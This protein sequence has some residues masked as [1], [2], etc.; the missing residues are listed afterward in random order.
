MIGS[1][2]AGKSI[3]NA[4]SGDLLVDSGS[5]N[6]GRSGCH[7][8]KRLAAP[9]LVA[10]VV[11]DPMAGTT[12]A[13]HRRKPGAGLA[14]R[15]ER[16]SLGRAVGRAARLFPWRK[17]SILKLGLE[18]PP[19]RPHWPAVG[20][21]APGGQPADGL[22]PSRMLLLTNTPPRST[23]KTAAFECWNR[24]TKWWRKAN[25]HA[26]G[27]PLMRQGAGPRRPHRDAASGAGWC[28]TSAAKSARAW[29]CRTYWPCSSARGE[30]ITD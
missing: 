14:K 20:R 30:A 9:R 11:A 15:S 1:N 22:K 12:G 29:T 25:D 28:W 26:D 4:I 21:P 7:P 19:D 16:R 13:D 10:Q 18:K 3:L 8:A 5:R 27:D 2:G 6:P 23:E 17:L 24:P